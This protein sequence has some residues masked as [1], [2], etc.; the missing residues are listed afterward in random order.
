[1]LKM[2]ATEVGVRQVAKAVRVAVQ[3]PTE[4]HALKTHLGIEIGH[5][6]DASRIHYVGI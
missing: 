3:S 5:F 6:R 4:R 2:T 1:M